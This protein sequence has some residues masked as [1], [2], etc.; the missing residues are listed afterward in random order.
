MIDI[1]K[2]GVGS[3]I[4]YEEQQNKFHKESMQTK[5]FDDNAIIAIH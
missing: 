5:M 1:V 4:A 3:M 2:N